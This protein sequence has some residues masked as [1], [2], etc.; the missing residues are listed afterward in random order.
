MSQDSLP[1]NELAEY[2]D[3]LFTVLDQLPNGSHPA[4]ELALESILFGGEGIQDNAKPYGEQQAER[5]SFNIAD[6]RDQY[7][8]GE[9]VTEFPAIDEGTVR[10]ENR[11]RL[12]S[13][14]IPPLS[15]KS[16]QVVPVYVDEEGLPDA[17]SILAEFPAEPQAEKPGDGVERLLDP[18]RFPGISQGDPDLDFQRGSGESPEESAKHAKRQN[19][20]EATETTPNSEDHTDEKGDTTAGNSSREKKRS[21]SELADVDESEW[22]HEDPRAESSHRKAQKRDPTEVVELGETISLVIKEADFT[23]HPPTVMGTKNKLVIFVIDAPQHVSKFDTIRA[24]VVDFGGK[25]NSAESVFV[26]YND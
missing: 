21:D 23:S 26:D 25:N 22:K 16:G 7:G 18:S 15:P 17:I 10:V 9:K 11:Q 12:D 8:T 3:S 5:N 1:P 20:A 24:K 14:C 19:T 2:Y 13:L 6:Y 4:W